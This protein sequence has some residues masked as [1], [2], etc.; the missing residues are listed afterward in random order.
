VRERASAV[1]ALPGILDR[2]GGLG[3][4]Q[5]LLDAGDD[6]MG[7]GQMQP[8]G[9]H[10]EV[11]TGQGGDVMAGDRAAVAGINDHTNRDIHGSVVP[12]PGQRRQASP[13]PGLWW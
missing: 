7:L 11:A 4:D 8:S 6:L 2:G 13:S 12:C 5:V 3:C 9:G 10:C 1:G